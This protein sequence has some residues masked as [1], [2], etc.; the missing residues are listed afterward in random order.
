METTSKRSYIKWISLWMNRTRNQVLG[1]AFNRGKYYIYI[2]SEKLQFIAIQLFIKK[3]Q[4]GNTA[5]V[6]NL[7]H[8]TQYHNGYH[9][10][11][12]R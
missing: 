6:K 12:C 8:F 3:M 10:H 1:A 11:G 2:H 9:S 4:Q 5:L 7:S